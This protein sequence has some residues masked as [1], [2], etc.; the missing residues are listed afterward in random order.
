MTVTVSKNHWFLKI[1]LILNNS[2]AFTNFFFEHPVSDA[3]G[4]IVLRPWRS[5]DAVQ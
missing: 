5:L 4:N 2:F 1:F 3:G